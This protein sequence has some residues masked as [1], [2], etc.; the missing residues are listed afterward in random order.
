MDDPSSLTGIVILTNDG[1]S[2]GIRSVGG[3]L[4][5]PINLPGDFKKE[6]LAVNLEAKIRHD[7]AGIRTPGVFIEIVRIERR[8]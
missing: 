4:Y 5:L 3:T 1:G 7:I 8:K 2:W 6:G